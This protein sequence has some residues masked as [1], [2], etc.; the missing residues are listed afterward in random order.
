MKEIL[1]M[2]AVLVATIAVLLAPTALWW[3]TVLRMQRQFR[4]SVHTGRNRAPA[5][6]GCPDPFA[7][8]ANAGTRTRA[9]NSAHLLMV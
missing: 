1:S 7:V 6:S 2:T 4:R 8:P 3:A 5:V 9:S